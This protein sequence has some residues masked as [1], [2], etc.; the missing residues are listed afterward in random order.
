MGLL[1]NN[2]DQTFT[3]LS[4]INLI[5]LEEKETKA[6]YKLRK[7][8]ASKLLVTLTKTQEDIIVG[9]LLGD[10]SMERPKA[11]HNARIRFDQTFPFHASYLMSI[12]SHFYNLSGKGP[13]V[14]I[15]KPD[16]A[17]QNR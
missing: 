5:S 12:F 17:K 4:S 6:P 13:L 10:A 1:Y 14:T 9:T 2:L 15:R 16:P 3:L 8:K 7:T 11:H